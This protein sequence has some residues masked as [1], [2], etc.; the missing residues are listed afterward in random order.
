MGAWDI[1]RREP[2]TEIG[3]RRLRCIRC[4]KPAAF[5]WQICADGNNWR[6]VCAVCDV[7][8]NELVLRW[9]GHPRADDLVNDYVAQ[10]LSAA[11]I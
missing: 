8:L 4:G 5:Q 2:Y 7:D 1:V 3:V 11:T 9:F 10:K 6:P